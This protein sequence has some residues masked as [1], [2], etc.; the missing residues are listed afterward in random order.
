MAAAVVVVGIVVASVVVTVVGAATVRSCS[1]PICF[2]MR[3]A[4]KSRHHQRGS[5]RQLRDR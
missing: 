4:I 2:L 1:T 3:A 5:T